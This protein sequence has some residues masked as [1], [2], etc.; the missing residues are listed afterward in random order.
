MH[1]HEKHV[2]SHRQ[3]DGRGQKKRGAEL[4][5]VRTMIVP[6]Y[7]A[8]RRAAVSVLESKRGL[9]RGCERFNLAVSLA[10]VGSNR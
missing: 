5:K 9:S 1:P 6:R 3:V 2:G 10:A 4:R 8:A 7:P